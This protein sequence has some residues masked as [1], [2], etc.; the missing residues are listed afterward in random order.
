LLYQS[1]NRELYLKRSIVKPQKF[2]F[3]LMLALM[4]WACTSVDDKI[5]K[6]HSLIP[7]A[8]MAQVRS[9]TMKLIQR[10]LEEEFVPGL[11]VALVNQEG[12]MW[13]EGCGE[14]NSRTG[15]LVTADTVFRA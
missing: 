4:M 5:S 7:E 12:A 11:S 14:A 2:L 3:M 13:V 15:R 10:L 6:Q 1:G 8:G 9:E